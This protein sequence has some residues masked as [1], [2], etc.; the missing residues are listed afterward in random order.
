M[1]ITILITKMVKTIIVS[2]L[3]LLQYQLLSLLLQIF[4][5]Q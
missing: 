5:L 2:L 3:L 4:I 1:T